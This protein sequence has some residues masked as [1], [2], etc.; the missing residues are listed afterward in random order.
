MDR[1]KLAISL[2]LAFGLTSA[3][4]AL[5]DEWLVFRPGSG[6]TP[7]IV[8]TAP[9]APVP[10][11]SVAADAT[12]LPWVQQNGDSDPSHY[13]LQG[14]QLV[15]APP[16][17]V[18]SPAPP[19]NAPDVPGFVVALRTD[20]TFTAPIRIGLSTLLGLVQMDIAN[21]PALQQDWQDAITTY[22]NSWL[23]NQVQA[24]ILQYAA[25]HN[26]PLTP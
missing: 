7:N 21:P 26:I 19:A 6:S 4:K 23:N 8:C 1:R 3:N 5:A 12:V 24:T 11:Q 14:G 18:Q 25:A 16:A 10:G 2:I 15:Y 22:G 20:P 17:P 13:Q 9:T